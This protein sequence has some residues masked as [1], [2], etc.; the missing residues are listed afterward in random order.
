MTAG[1]GGAGDLLALLVMR[2]QVGMGGGAC[3]FVGGGDGERGGGR[4]V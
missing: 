1:G 2:V 3:G 4:G